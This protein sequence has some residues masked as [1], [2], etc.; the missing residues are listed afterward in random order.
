[1]YPSSQ[2]VGVY[3]LLDVSQHPQKTRVSGW[4]LVG[5]PPIVF[6]KIGGNFRVSVRSEMK[7]FV[8]VQGARESEKRS[9]LPVR[10]HF[11]TPEQRRNR[12]KG[13]FLD[14]YDRHTWAYVA[15]TTKSRRC[16]RRGYFH[17]HQRC[18]GYKAYSK[19]KNQGDTR[20]VPRPSHRA[21][22]RPKAPSGHVAPRRYF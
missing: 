11:Q 19:Q 2:F 14:G 5:R 10:E 3:R 12:A 17:R 7:I 4:K 20:H 8:R 21:C 18:K 9:V 13:P 22:N 15:M 1:M 16:R 6:R